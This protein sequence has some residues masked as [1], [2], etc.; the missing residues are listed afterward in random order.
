[1][2]SAILITFK[3]VVIN[4]N[5]VTTVSS[6]FTTSKT[7]LHLIYYLNFH[8]ATQNPDVV[9]LSSLTLTYKFLKRLILLQHSHCFSLEYFKAHIS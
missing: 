2:K 7:L 3:F 8:Q 9:I 6:I 4:Y 1:M 5:A